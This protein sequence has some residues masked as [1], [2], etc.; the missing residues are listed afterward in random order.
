M[1]KGWNQLLCSVARSVTRSACALISQQHKPR[2]G[3]TA[4]QGAAELTFLYTHFL[5]MIF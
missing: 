3:R 4:A 5:R 2:E 1:C